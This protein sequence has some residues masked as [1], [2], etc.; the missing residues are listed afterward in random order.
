MKQKAPGVRA[1]VRAE[2]TAEIKAAATRQL[3]SGGAASLSLR[4]IAR[5]MGMASS[6]IYRYFASRDELLTA[7]IIDAYHSIGVAVEEADATMERGDYAGRFRAI[8]NAIRTWSQANP[9]EYALI[10]G[11]PVPGYAAPDD[12]IDPATRVPLALIAVLVDRSSDVRLGSLP[13]SDARLV[14]LPSNRPGSISESGPVVWLSSS[15]SK[16]V[17]I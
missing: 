7:L 5:E 14:W 12:T 13:S 6:A 4:A 15:P 3:A 17:T 16:A 8:A 9:H 10:Y 11:S 2:L 1:R